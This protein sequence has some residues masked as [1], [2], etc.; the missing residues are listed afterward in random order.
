MAVSHKDWELSNKAV[1]IFLSG[2]VSKPV[3]F[4]GEK[5]ANLNAKIWTIFFK[6][7]I[8]IEVQKAW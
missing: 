3:M 2:P 7:Y 6:Q 8:F 5:V 4:T 1:Y